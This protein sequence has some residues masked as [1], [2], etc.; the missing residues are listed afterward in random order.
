MSPSSGDLPPTERF[1]ERAG[2]YARWRPTY[3]EA[4]LRDAIQGLG[5]PNGLVVADI[6][7]GTGISSR[8]V[9]S[10]GPRVFAIE[11]NAE[12]RGA[13]EPHP[14]VTWRDGR[15]ESTGLPDRS[16]GLVLCAQA[17]HWFE[18]APALREFRRILRPGGRLAILWNQKDVS[19]P[20]TKEYY[21]LVD[22]AAE[23]SGQHKVRS[24]ERHLDAVSASGLF[25]PQPV[26]IYRH[27]QAL[28]EEGFLGRTRSASYV[29]KE[30]AI[31]D[32]LLA[33]LRALHARHRGPDGIAR[34]VYKTELFLADVP[35]A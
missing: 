14:R 1:T 25:A 8:Q 9:A 27:L 6:G 15:A 32:R 34:L 30:G 33:D 16:V 11:P 5:D 18:A 12:M 22:R 2:D 3:P 29:P 4:A 17:F 35:A 20:F 13:A 7:A 31:A 19:D 28:D 21:G 24:T 23:E 26:R 10:L